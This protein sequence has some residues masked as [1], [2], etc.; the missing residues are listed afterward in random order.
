LNLDIVDFP[1]MIKDVNA[2]E[3]YEL[4]ENIQVWAFWGA[5]YCYRLLSKLRE[6]IQHNKNSYRFSV[7]LL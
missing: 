3:C 1:G 4:E 7:I 5:V 6:E 2:L